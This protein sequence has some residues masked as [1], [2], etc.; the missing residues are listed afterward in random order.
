MDWVWAAALVAAGLVASTSNAAV[1]L[2]G[3]LLVMPLLSLWFPPAEVVA[4]T[5]P[6]FL[7]SNAVN[8]WRYRRQAEWRAFFWMVP[9]ILVGTVIGT[10]FL[11]SAP[12]D[13]IRWIMG[14]VAILFTG[15][16]AYRLAFRRSLRALPVWAGIPISLASGVASALTNIGGTII[17]LA[18]LGWDLAPTAFVGTLNA[19]MLAMSASKIA[20]FTSTGLITWRGALLALPS[21]PTVILGS[22]IGHQLH[23]RLSPLMFRWILVSVIGASATLLVLGY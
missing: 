3:G 13:L 8:W 1:G 17:S 22:A 4:Y 15:Q 6:M 12:P 19:I 11:R 2:G 5:V 16:E 20:M 18:L 7:A 23:R 9:G 10:Q 21:L 14:G